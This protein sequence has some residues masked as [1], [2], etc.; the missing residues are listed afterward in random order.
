LLVTVVCLWALGGVGVWAGSSPVSDGARSSPIFHL[1]SSDALV[2]S[3][4][5]RAGPALSSSSGEVTGPQK[6]LVVTVQFTDHP[7]TTTGKIEETVAALDKYWQDVSYGKISLTTTISTKWYTLKQTYAYYGANPESSSKK[8][9][10]ITD[11]VSLTENDFDYQQFTY[12]IIVHA[13]NSEGH[14]MNAADIWDAGTIGRGTVSTA[15]H[16]AVTLG[17]SIIAELDPVGAYAHELGHNFSLPDLWDYKI[18]QSACPWCDTFVG[19]WDLMAHGCWSGNG[20]TPARLSSW[21]LLKLGWLEDSALTAIKVGDQTQK[22]VRPL[23][24]ANPSIIKATVTDST[25]YLIEARQ[26]TGW[27][28]NL[29]DEGILI[30]YVD[31]RKG[32]GEGPVRYKAPSGGLGKAWKTSQFFIDEANQFVVSGVS[33][34]ANFNFQV[35]TYGA[36]ASQKYDVTVDTPYPD[37][38]VVFDGREYRTTQG[39]ELV[40]KEVTFGAHNLTIQA[41][42]IIDQGVRAVFVSWSDHETNNSRTLVVVANT[43]VTAEYKTQYLLTLVSE[44]PVNGSGWCDAG[45]QARISASA[46]INY[47]NETRRAFAG[48]SGDLTETNSSAIVVMDKPKTITARWM[49]QYLLTITGQYGSPQA[50][51]WY[52]TNTVAN[53]STPTIVEVQPGVRAAFVN[54]SGNASGTQ[55]NLALMMDKPKSIT[56]NWQLQHSVSVQILDAN[57]QPISAPCPVISFSHAGSQVALNRSGDMW[58]DVG[59][60]TI[61]DARWHGINVTATDTKYSTS[62]NGVWQ[63]RLHVYSA[64]IHVQSIITSLPVK[65]AS[66]TLRLPDNV[67]LAAITDEQGAAVF[68][69]LPS[70]LSY[71][72][73]VT[74]QYVPQEFAL[75]VGPSNANVTVKMPVLTEISIIVAVAVVVVLLLLVVRRRGRRAKDIRRRKCTARKLPSARSKRGALREY[76]ENF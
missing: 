32:N 40:I 16:G 52:N 43:N 2:L 31:D 35:A 57:G 74:A 61:L 24:S 37:L 39:G 17:V 1:D 56:T 7:H 64:T 33:V 50:A 14:S 18:S 26:K 67:V 9:E 60:Y 76:F 4:V 22:Q 5:S 30:F 38:P 19:E 36:S 55:A 49:M 42:H 8:I 69:Q 65:G 29:P 72:A 59:D 23:G 63:I 53:V 13:G 45:S 62:P 66:V 6:I 3:E 68:P 47:G 58:L 75:A 28:R 12:L 54:W 41:L 44:V 71:R 34:D 48:W 46:V 21:S 25:Y 20:T 10:L 27:D 15:T 73:A 70:G 51:G 11:A